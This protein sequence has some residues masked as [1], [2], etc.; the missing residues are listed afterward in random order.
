M[1]LPYIVGAMKIMSLKNKPLS[2][3]PYRHLTGSG[4]SKRTSSTSSSFSFISI[5]YKATK[6]GEQQKF[7]CICRGESEPG[8]LTSVEGTIENC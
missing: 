7:S 4:P 8:L 5:N 3:I 2:I 6:R 1:L